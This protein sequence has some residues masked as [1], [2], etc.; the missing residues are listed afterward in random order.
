VHR[1]S[2]AVVLLLALGA[3]ACGKSPTE[4]ATAAAKEYVKKLGARDGKG[5]C[6][7]MTTGLQRDFTDT[8]TRTATQFKGKPCATIMQAALATIPQGQLKLFADAQIRNVRL[9][10]DENRGT[11]VYRVGRINVD[12]RVA[13]EKDEWKVS[14]CVPQAGGA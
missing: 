3:T 7:Q 10:D 14:C 6:A 9:N 2:L 12:G 1:A 5:A 11:F 8:V 13:K 4:Q